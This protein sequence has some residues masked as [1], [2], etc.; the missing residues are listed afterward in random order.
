MSIRVVS[1]ALLVS[2][3]GLV[4][5]AH[6]GARVQ[7]GT[8]PSDAPKVSDILADLEENDAALRNFKA[9][10]HFTVKA[11]SSAAVQQ[12]TGVVQFRKPADLYVVGRGPLGAK[13]FEVRYADDRYTVTFDK[14]TW[15]GNWGD[16]VEGTTWQVAPR[17]I[18]QEMFLPKTWIAAGKGKARLVEYDA[19]QHK[20]VLLIGSEKRPLRR[21]EVTGPPWDVTKHEL[22]DPETGEVT[23]S[24]ALGDYR[25]KDGVRI[26]AFVEASFPKQETRLKFTMSRID[27]NTELN[28]SLFTIEKQ[29]FDENTSH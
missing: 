3:L 10:G 2:F 26:P 28:D 27:P 24:T 15:S 20:A 21:V 14:Q 8:L 1:C 12:C 4:G 9:Y 7:R 5:C 29:T 16:S 18:A 13:V 23:A 17:E 25:E 11:P 6:L 22:Y 19:S